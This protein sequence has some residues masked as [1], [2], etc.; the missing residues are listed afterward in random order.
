MLRRKSRVGGVTVGDYP[1]FGH[2][3]SQQEWLQGKVR[4]QQA[5]I[6]KLEERLADQQKASAD[7]DKMRLAAEHKKSKADAAFIE[8]QRLREEAELR[9]VEVEKRMEAVEEEKRTEAEQLR[10]AKLT[11]SRLSD[12][13]ADLLKESMKL[14]DEKK[15][16]EAKLR[17]ANDRISKIKEVE[18]SSATVSKQLA[19]SRSAVTSLSTEVKTLREQYEAAERLNNQV[20][21][22][23]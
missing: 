21:N 20:R 23:D 14:A 8:E 10:Q 19:A 2:Q 17:G 15:A 7:S 16:A 13:N 9:K 22:F 6:R 1:L 18:K 4:D 11:A 3:S 5:E 12:R